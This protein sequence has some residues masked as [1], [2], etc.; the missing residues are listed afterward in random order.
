MAL[1]DALGGNNDIIDPGALAD[2]LFRQRHPD[3]VAPNEPI[4]PA[5]TASRLLR[6][7]MQ[8]QEK[9]KPE[10]LAQYGIAGGAPVPP[11]AAPA[12]PEDLAKFGVAGGAP[13]GP[14]PAAVQ[15]QAPPVAERGEG[16][17][18]LG[19]AG[20]VQ[21]TAAGLGGAVKG[22]GQMMT[23]A[24]SFRPLYDAYIKYTTMGPEEQVKFKENLLRPGFKVEGEQQQTPGAGIAQ[25]STN[26]LR[27]SL[28]YSFISKHDTEGT[29]VPFDQFT[30]HPELA[31]KPI[32]GAGEAVTKAGEK[33]APMTPAEKQTYTG[34]IG[35]GLGQGLATVGTAA[36]GSVLGGP[37]G[38]MAAASAQMGL[39]SYSS[40][41]DQAIA[42]GAT[43]EMA[44]K[45]AGIDGVIG[46]GM[47]LAPFA[48]AMKPII[49]LQPSIAGF[50][51][52]K[53]AQAAQGGVALGTAGEIQNFLEKQVAE[54][55]S[56]PPYRA[57]LE[58]ERTALQQRIDQVKDT[59]GNEAWLKKAEEAKKYYG[60]QI[61]E[62]SGYTPDAKRIISSI[63]A[64][65]II[66]AAHP[67]H[68][69]TARTAEAGAAAGEQPGQV[70]GAARPSEPPP[71][72]GGPGA[73]PLGTI[74]GNARLRQARNLNE[75][76]G[77]PADVAAW[78]KEQEEV[79]R[80]R[81]GGKP[82]TTEEPIPK[83]PYK[84]TTLEE[85]DNVLRAH[86]F[87]EEY[88][89]SLRET[90]KARERALNEALATGTHTGVEPAQEGKR[91]APVQ[92][93]EP[94]DL[95]KVAAVVK[96]DGT[97]EQNEA[98]NIQRGH[99]RWESL[100]GTMEAPPGGIRG[101]VSPDG[102]PFHTQLPP[103]VA[104]GYWKGLPV[105]EDGQ[106]PD[107]FVGN[108]LGTA[109]DAFVINELDNDTGKFRQTKSFV[110]FETEQD[111]ID[112]YLGTSSKEPKMIGDVVRLS[113]EEFTERAK[114]GD[115]S[116]PVSAEMRGERA[117][118]EP[119]PATLATSEAEDTDH[120]HR[121]AIEDMLRQAG[122]EP[123]H[124]EPEVIN[125]L[126]AEI[127]AHEGYS[128]E[129][130]F[131]LAVV[132]HAV[133]TGG[134]TLE[135]VKQVYGDT[136]AD[137]VIRKE[138]EHGKEEASTAV[139]AKPTPPLQLS[140][141]PSGSSVGGTIAA[142]E[143]QRVP[144]GSEGGRTGEVQ[145]AE[146][147][148]AGGETAVT[149]ATKPGG[150]TA[151]APGTEDGR[152]VAR[153]A[154][155]GER[156]AAT[157]EGRPSGE[158][159]EPARGKTPRPAKVAGGVNLSLLQYIGLNGGMKPDADLKALGLN[160]LSR[161]NIP[162]VGYRNLVRG[163]G[164]D[165][166]QLLEKLREGG[167]LP[168]ADPTKPEDIG[169]YRRIHE[170]LD[171][172]HNRGR[173]QYKIGE[174]AGVGTPGQH[175]ED[176]NAHALQ[177][178]NADLDAALAEHKLQIEPEVRAEAVKYILEGEEPINAVE[179][180]SVQVDEDKGLAKPEQFDNIGIK[181]KA[182]EVH[183]ETAPGDRTDT[184]GER[185]TPAAAQAGAGAQAGGTALGPSAG[186]GSEPKPSAAGE[187]GGKP[188][189]ERTEAG[190]G[191]YIIPG[192]EPIS[193]AERAKRAAAER[194]KPK[195]VQKPPD[196]GIFSDSSQQ[197]DLVEQAQKPPKPTK[198][199]DTLERAR[200]EP[201]SL[202]EHFA[203]HLGSG[204]GFAGILAARKF[205]KDAGFSEDPKQVEEALELA[206]VKTAREIVKGEG[207]PR[208]KY[209]ILV[210]LYGRQPT[211]GT[212]T[213]T[214]MRDQ[215]F[216]TPIPL[217]YVASRLAEIGPET[218]VYEPTAGNGALLIETDPK[219]VIA[220]ELNPERAR[221]LS[222]I[223]VG[224][225]TR[226]DASEVETGPRGKVDR[227][228][229][230]PPFG[231][232]KEAP[233]T[234]KVFDLS[235]IQR[236][237]STHEIDHAIAFRALEAMKDDGKAVLII[238]SVNKLA[239]SPEAR[240]DAYNSKAKRE[241][242]KTLYDHYN[243]IDHVTVSG[244]LY[245]RQGAGWP[246]DVIS[247]DGRG[248]SLRVLPAVSPPKVYDS[249]DAL[250]GLIHEPVHRDEGALGRQ[251]GATVAPDTT[252]RAGVPDEGM[253]ADDR[254]GRHGVGL[255]GSIEPETV[256]AG[257]PPDKPGNF[258]ADRDGVAAE[259]KPREPGVAGAVDRQA[260]AER[261]PPRV[262]KETDT[263]VSYKP[264][265]SAYGLGT[266]VPV[267]M[268]KSIG[269]ALD[270]LAKRVGDVDTFVAK[271][272]GYNKSDLPKYFASEQIDSIALALDNIKRGKGYITGDMTGTGKGKQNAAIIRW[273]LQNGRIPVFV[274]EK[275]NLYKDMYRDLTDTG[276]QDYLGRE[277]K[278][279]M[280]NAS[281]RVALDEDGKTIL[282]SGQAKDHNTLL[283]SL[284]SD[285]KEFRKHFDVVLTNYSQMQTMKG[286]DTA[287]RNFLRNII[288]NSVLILD[289]S[290]N[291]G[292]QK[293]QFVVKGKPED[294]A[295]YARELV[296][297][298][299][300]VFYS[301][302]TY[303]KRP[304]VMDLYAATDMALA[305]A[306]PKDLGAAIAKG[307]VPMQQAVASMLAR[308][309]QYIRR[310]RSFDGVEYNTPTLP[311]H[312]DTYDGVSHSLSS[313]QDFSRFVKSIAKEMD[314][315]LKGEAAGTGFDN[316]T[317]DAG[318]K[319]VAFT[320]IMHNI[321]N[322]YLLA[323]KA[324]PAAAAAIEALK[325]GE[326]PVLTVANTMEAFLND[327][328]REMD[329]KHGDAINAGFGDVLKKYLDRTRTLIIKKPFAK[330][331]E[332]ERKYLTDAELGPIGK[333]F[334]DA[335]KKQIDALDLSNMPISPIDAL[336]SELAK[337][338]YRV[339]EITGRGNV[340]DY[341]GKYPIYKPRA[342]G[343]V[344]IAG[345][346]ETIKKFNNGEFDAL[347]MNQAGSTGISLHASEK[348]KDQKQR[349][350]FIVQ[351]EGNIDTH[352]QLLGRVHRTGQV[353]LPKYTQMIA[354]IPAEKRP[355]A[356][357]AKKMASLNANT[358]ATRGSAMTAKDVPDFI[359]AYGDMVA[360]AMIA[361]DPALNRRLGDAV[362]FKENGG[363]DIADAM[364]K[365]TGRIPLL[366]LKDQE[367]MYAHLESEYHALLE[368]MKAAGENSLEAQTMDLQA[369]KLDEREV[370]ARKAEGGDSP[371]AAPVNLEH[372]SVKRLGKPFKS[373]EVVGKVFEGISE[374]APE[375]LTKDNAA[376][377]LANLADPYRPLGAKV[378]KAH[379]AQAK[380]ASGKFDDYKRGIIDDIETPERQEAERMKLDAV[381]DRWQDMHTTLRPGARITLKTSNGNL[382]GVVLNVTQ[383]GKPKNPLALS[384]WKA[385][386]AIADATRQITVPFSRLWPDGRADPEDEYA[387]EVATVSDWL[388]N[389]KQTLERFDSQQ[390][391]AREER[392]I[393]TGNMLAAYDWLNRQGR[394]INYT[395][396]EGH[397]NQGILTPRD[398]DFAE[399]A[400]GKKTVIEAPAD[401]AKWISDHPDEWIA[402]QDNV[403]RVKTRG[404]YRAVISVEAAKRIGG[405]YYLDR[406]LTDNV[407]DFVKR[408]GG[409]LAEFSVDRLPEAI[410]RLQALGAKFEAS[411][412][413]PSNFDTS[414]KS[415]MAE[416]R[417]EPTAPK[418]AKAEPQ[419]VH[420][421][422]R[423]TPRAE[424]A[425]PR[426]QQAIDDL[427]TQT[428]GE[429][430]GRE[431]VKE[432]T[433]DVGPEWNIPKNARIL[434]MYDT[435]NKLMSLAL[436]A[437]LSTLKQFGVAIH[438]IGHAVEH[439]FAT[440]EEMDLL[441]SPRAKA[442]M[443]RN[444]IAGYTREFITST[445][446]GH[447]PATTIPEHAAR[448]RAEKFV[449][450]ISDTELRQENLRFWF[451]NRLEDKVYGS[452]NLHI[453]VRRYYER[454]WNFLGRLQ[455][456]MHMNGFREIT[457]FY[458]DILAGEM[459][460]RSG[461]EERQ[462]DIFRAAM[463]EPVEEKP[464]KLA[465]P[466]GRTITLGAIG[467]LQGLMRRAKEMYQS[468]IAPETVSDRAFEADPKF[469]RYKSVQ[470]QQKDAI[471]KQSWDDWNYWNK[472]PVRDRLAWL[473][474][475]E[476]GA[477]IADP[478][479]AQM[480]A[481]Y[482]RMLDTNWRAEK[483]LGST[484]GF[485]AE[486]IPHVWKDRPRG[487]MTWAAYAERKRQQ[488][489]PTWFQKERTFDTIEE[490]M[491]AGFELKYTNPI[492]LIMHR[493]LSGVDMR[494]RMEL[495]NRLQTMDL[496]VPGYDRDLANQGWQAI[497]APGQIVP[498]DS[499]T[500]ML[501]PDVQMLWHNAVT[502][503]T[504]WQSEAPGGGI[505]RGWMAVKNVWVPLKLMASA[506]HIL[507]VLHISYS[508]GMTR[509]ISNLTKG[510]D[511]VG[512]L[513]AL[514]EGAW[515]PMH[516]APGATAGAVAGALLGSTAMPVL[517]T[518]AGAL[519]GALAGSVVMGAAKKLGLARDLR[520][521][522]T[523]ARLAWEKDR[524]QWT[525][526]EKGLMQLMH[527][528][529]FV[530]QLDERMRI[531]ARKGLAEAVQTILRKEAGIPDW[532]KTAYHGI[533]RV[534][535]YMQAP[536]FERWIPTLKA[537]A[538]L[539]AANDLLRR[540]P[541]YMNDRIAREVAL[542]A[543]AKSIDDRMGEMF[544]G[545]LFWNP[546]LKN[547]GTASFLSLGWNL[548]LIRGGG[549][550]ISGALAGA[551]IGSSVPGVGTFIGA[552]AGAGGGGFIGW[553]GG[554]LPFFRDR[555]RGRGKKIAAEA[556]EKRIYANVYMYTAFLF[557]AIL[558]YALT[559]KTPETPL[560]VIYPQVGGINPDGTPRRA[561]TMFYTREAI[562]LKHH[563]ESEGGQ[564]NMKGFMERPDAYMKGLTD[565]VWSKMMFQPF[566]ELLKNRDFY[567]YNITDV[568]A[569]A[570]KQTWQAVQHTL[571]G[572]EPMSQS[573][574]ERAKATGGTQ[575]DVTLSYLGF[576]PAPSYATKN[577]V[578]NRIA[579]LFGEHG[580]AETK[581]EE[582]AEG[583]K[584]VS[585]ARMAIML[586]KRSHDSEAL[587]AAYEQGKK[588][589]LSSKVMGKIS[590]DSPMDVYMFGKLP[591][592]DQRAILRDYPQEDTKKYVPKA[593]PKVKSE[594]LER[595]RKELLE[596]MPP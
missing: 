336:K 375:N 65:G 498:Q 314:K 305:V 436:H 285:P 215:A 454:F 13:P 344:S 364:R 117:P 139:G 582:L 548:G 578:E 482:R 466:E 109:R 458:E 435:G 529:G 33:L 152:P 207:T 328:A 369:K 287:R 62:A 514:A 71:P 457:D 477:P 326:K 494:Q 537:N 349:H 452:E 228:L 459:T 502:A 556:A 274:T 155:G 255:A 123:H 142:P 200:A 383:K 250:G 342:S 149:E 120:T 521:Q 373:D 355:A 131:Q 558:M 20:V 112:A 298:A 11:G 7:H 442:I 56:N 36:V 239:A 53:L 370:V 427:I 154:P 238:G 404:S 165:N 538:Y 449:K 184:T 438:E 384:T 306:D 462:P 78:R 99:F 134:L 486:Y 156:P 488:I 513:R 583:R 564:L 516:A 332:T 315:D 157:D 58:A 223:G 264:K 432:I 561:N 439:R 147:K 169:V 92:L 456:L 448:A 52:T 100:E 327:Y 541:E 74:E 484:A 281:Q 6:K 46:A 533:R 543:I 337:E 45:E 146:N 553:G 63:A 32:I 428:L 515:R 552:L 329:I 210:D 67:P 106:H 122:I 88:I 176:E 572:L 519:Y 381:K 467:D 205:A 402:S 343:E 37:A 89:E 401:V 464:V 589:G 115:L 90:P 474:A 233:K 418:P 254:G 395:D 539:T 421:P 186:T 198:E 128:P 483:A 425:L 26:E 119:L 130:A 167:Y 313:I 393:A 265:S 252:G 199:Q 41:F 341:S 17:P 296:D 49:A 256:R 221:N 411:M 433:G 560:D 297:K 161:T 177:K 303:A 5:L 277:P 95:Q 394:I 348:V 94:V 410:T 279:L 194:L 164:M 91:E 293:K 127:H 236:G 75:F 434:G 580:A 18:I 361:E 340:I 568:N 379:E 491:A 290:H 388:E 468:G 201:K 527:E 437:N 485:V 80:K 168:E 531:A 28:L 534:V 170:M 57:K 292:G 235:D 192:T 576:G 276:I 183:G 10:D 77:E 325:R 335:A 587:Q 377:L 245:S 419:P 185:P 390:S 222:E 19:A 321:I 512:A 21:G 500:W 347:L 125:N 237:Y 138:P 224:T 69:P 107:V 159:A 22:A 501:A 282:K 586:A 211:L 472:K 391:D 51:A 8:A 278:F 267:N 283:S 400:A 179:Q 87:D 31:S 506:F 310:E 517:G 549:S 398:F 64:G 499:K 573:S 175:I 376:D 227:V 496:A 248:K 294:R 590:P 275:P 330:K 218:S 528:G 39:S 129:D 196:E 415:Y 358:T 229:A 392:Y 141:P 15:P 299:N 291:A 286:E 216:S 93:A 243:V 455:S 389:H 1:A 426:I 424:E 29:T 324:K 559:R 443:Q 405:Q 204:E 453:G 446:R 145:A 570:Y 163:G 574:A 96:T 14:A 569:N 158:A 397:T 193:D 414:T 535:E 133:H 43:P 70:P 97:P 40:A 473:Q 493:L 380:E 172:E 104:Y 490:G 451:Q 83:A 520:S 44:A 219:R 188:A 66:G 382:A 288:P 445:D 430:Q 363:L 289:E 214:S 407:G 577:A 465:E 562:M 429:E 231:A 247:I 295:G 113:P 68:F 209:V 563:I 105:G 151:G 225:V 554:K 54:A 367:T 103:G 593:L 509:A 12:T 461:T 365:V 309:G 322:Q 180:A 258:P 524:R 182:D 61:Q 262:E 460:K 206:V 523:I 478:H 320:S 550:T 518:Y 302:A 300:G 566:V 346:N 42:K 385:N 387:I 76:V 153:H 352:M 431:F 596:A 492:D 565:M 417:L 208:E 101:G 59:P 338:G 25:A 530:P 359:N 345:R 555:G 189:T 463:A 126:A 333:R 547:I 3:V 374:K 82:V 132:R 108:K 525:P 187:P 505:Y 81:A 592:P 567:G 241:F 280:T 136:I 50:V 511:P 271:E 339:G 202:A 526:E 489:G 197:T 86:G 217:A 591:E 124:V 2:Q 356:V 72:P 24:E 234:S 588:A 16:N 386:V 212:R 503:K 497:G 351:P 307:S 579:A 266:L 162:G 178:A 268:R 542:R 246:V 48:A 260:D 171:E 23:G 362:K 371:F 366:P 413:P 475:A 47:G 551:V 469:A 510:R 284:P 508:Q 191:Q 470:A 522:G 166:D 447:L 226:K 257:S 270:S 27:K 137:A 143:T 450:G 114:A 585:E 261:R 357:L 311:V 242:F 408:S 220:N 420:Q 536:I 38:G 269:D 55:Y 251:A 372:V 406:E 304:D 9:S 118:A 173:L 174:E 79:E 507:H 249:W 30:L 571:L 232:V 259:H 557:A 396:S 317:G 98:N 444:V 544:Y 546:V 272:L 35:Q 318:A 73:A 378:T 350:M 213:S 34:A 263:Q 532:L 331:G 360:G 253:R 581:S 230:N 102:T 121:K 160:Y 412:E 240:S 409:M 323:A 116:K 403:V 195:V 244:D 399:H 416:P 148:P 308:A 480:A 479:E 504:L 423:L 316:A 422:P 85:E 135:Q 203:E 368:Q 441:K 150:E 60:E 334:Y 481:R 140:P 471:V 440:D 584:A 110:G 595:Q 144:S 575:Q 111:A 487:Q 190:P 84:P 4:D 312:K 594:F 540:H 181:V 273:A 319:S 301:S 545:N 354:D 495:L 476:T 353:V